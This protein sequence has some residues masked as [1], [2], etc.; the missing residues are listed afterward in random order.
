[1]QEKAANKLPGLESHR[2]L[3]VSVFVIFPPESDL[4]T[5]ETDQAV[6][7]NGN[8][9]R[10]AAEVVQHLI[11]AA[12]RGLRVPTHSIFQQV[13]TRA[14]K[15]CGSASGAGLLEG[16][17]QVTVR[18]EDAIAGSEELMSADFTVAKELK[19]SG[20]SCH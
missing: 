7:G 15:V 10:I 18:I 14:L 8:A 3:L 1:V 19:P 6:V 4:P 16:K 2:F 13:F 5:I 9:V 12:E 17:Y 11:R 20:K